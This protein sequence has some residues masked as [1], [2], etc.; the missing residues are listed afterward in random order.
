MDEYLAFATK[1]AHAAGEIMLQHFQIGVATEIKASEG[2]TPVT[3][4]DKAINQLVV[5]SV[6]ST[7]PNHAVSG[8]EQS[9]A[10]EGAPYTWVCDP[11]DG[12]IPYSAGI[13]TNVFSLALVDNSDGQPIVAV[14]H[15]PYMKRLYT[16]VKGQ[17]AFVNGE[18]AHVNHVAVFADAMIGTSSQRSKLVDATALKE[19]IIGT[20]FR[21]MCFNSTIYEAMLVATG[22]FAGQAFVGAGA[23]DVAAA[24]LI[25]REAGG[26][27]TDIF[28]DNQRYDDQ[29]RGSL[30]SNGLVHDELVRLARESKLGATDGKD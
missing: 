30:M 25:V 16:A 27:A 2:N 23:Y 7:Y 14:V 8:E 22:Q 5:E 18:R 28:G 26:K 3:V 10:N 12:T 17:G 15:D 24:A 29:V 4:A 1:L 21:Q 11:I 19:R 9:L 20:C 6:R 13:P